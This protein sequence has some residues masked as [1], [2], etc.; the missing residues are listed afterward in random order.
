MYRMVLFVL[1]VLL[2]LSACTSSTSTA[3]SLEVVSTTDSYRLVRHMFGETQVPLNPSRVLALGEEGLLIDLIDSGIRPVAASVNLSERV[4]LLSAE[5][6]AGIALFPSAGDI[7]LETLSAYQPDFI[8][9]TKFF[10]DQIGYQRLS[11]IAPT[12]ALNGATPLTQYLETLTVFGCAEEA[13]REVDTLRTEIQRVATV[14]G[15]A[16]QRVSLVTV[17]PGMNVALW[18]DGP[19]PI[20][21]LVRTLGVQIRPNPTTVT[22]L[23]IRNGRAFISLEQLSMADGDMILLLQ[24]ADVEGEASAV[25]EMIVH[26][27]WQQLPAVQA[28]RVVKLDRIGFPGLRGQRVLLTML[29]E[30]LA[31]GT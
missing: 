8:I 31:S 28:Q 16:T 18:F 4:P 26:P 6:L 22:D 24:T 9:G 17:Y 25:A 19:S 21:L 1:L 3:Q 14:R 23:N 20:P 13:Q 10:I 15:T 30:I 5:E 2:L 7:S 27:L 12:V 11:Q 29:E